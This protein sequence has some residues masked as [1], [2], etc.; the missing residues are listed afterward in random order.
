MLRYRADI[1]GIRALAVISTVLFHFEVPYFSGGFV[2]VDVFFVVSGYLIFSII[3]SDIY[4]GNF[5]FLRFISGR[6]Y[7]IAIP[8]YFVI[9]LSFLASYVFYLPGDAIELYKSIPYA[10]LFLSN[11]YFGKIE[12]YFASHSMLMH[13]WS[14]SLEMQFYIFFSIFVIFIIRFFIDRVVLILVTV[15]CLSF[16]L[17]VLAVEYAP[18]PAFYHLPFRGF[19]F[20]IGAFVSQYQQF[21]PRGR[22]TNIYLSFMGIGLI[23]VGILVLNP[24]SEFPGAA[25]LVP[26]LGAAA[27]ILSGQGQGGVITELLRSRP[28]V[29]V[30]NISYPLY[31]WHWPLFVTY[32]YVTDQPLGPLEL[33]SIFLLAIALSWMTVVLIERPVLRLRYARRA[34]VL[35]AVTLPLLVGLVV[36]SVAGQMTGGFSYRVPS[37]A[38]EQAAYSQD[39]RVQV[40]DCPITGEA[41]EQ[42]A[43]DGVYCSFPSSSG[44]VSW[45]LWGD[46]HANAL[47]NSL[48]AS[49][50][51]RENGI[52][53]GNLFGCPPVLGVDV[54]L[55]KDS[56]CSRHNQQILEILKGSVDIEN[57]V[58]FSRFAFYLYGVNNQVG[59]DDVFV[60]TNNLISAPSPADRLVQFEEG[61]REV[62]DELTSAGKTVILL[63]PVPEGGLNV[64]KRSAMAIRDGYAGIPEISYEAHLY[65]NRHV[66]PVLDGLKPT[67]PG[68]LIKVPVADLFCRAGTCKVAEDGVPL[69]YDTNHVT[70]GKGAGMI[71]EHMWSLLDEE[72]RAGS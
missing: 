44:D 15:F 63:Y 53:D 69:Y 70:A 16:F 22:F 55:W 45:A 24:Y 36:L 50:K 32:R 18:W 42:R 61:L 8:Y 12:S 40:G 64:P 62:V 43:Q 46:S 29:F 2:G 5:S 14:L 59:P 28:F 35:G 6:F 3:K 37:S 54:P 27:L 30:G 10:S 47:F 71:V 72:A 66:S 17:S 49:L 25:A 38:L 60:Y 31:L 4:I 19:E 65:R 51:N 9:F 33:F 67:A 58:L 52:F 1:Q 11:F 48:H 26:C 39:S 57:V 13:T 41:Y 56:L 21:V 68:R 20:L 34:G 23:S 7:R